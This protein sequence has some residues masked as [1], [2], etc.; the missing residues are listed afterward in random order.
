MVGNFIIF[1][2]A[3]F[4]VLG[5]DT[6]NAGLVGLSISYALQVSP[7]IIPKCNYQ[8]MLFTKH[9]QTSSFLDHANPELAGANDIGRGDE[10]RRRG[11]DKGVR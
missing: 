6:M 4:A 3:L 1:F 2:A 9:T 8:K 10:H 5:R 11:E 7:E